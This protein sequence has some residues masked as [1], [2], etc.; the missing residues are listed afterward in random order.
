[1]SSSVA[2][3]VSSPGTRERTGFAAFAA[4]PVLAI[5]AAVGV[6]LAAVSG[7]Y[8]YFGDELYFLAAGRHL[9]WGY[10]DQPPLLPLLARALDTIAPGSVVVLR[11]PAVAVTVAGVVFGALIAREL[12]GARKAQVLTAAAYAC[13]GQFLGTG[14]YLATSTF[15]PFLWTVLLW[16]LTRWLRTRADGLLVWAG[17]VTAIAVNV[18]FLVLGF[19]LVLAVAVLVCGPRE[20]LKR[21]KLWAGAL[22]ALAGVLPTVLWQAANGWP[23]IRMGAAISAEVENVYGGRLL[24]LPGMALAAGILAG[25]VLLVAGLVKLL[26]TPE[27]RFL[28]W[29]TLGL[30]A[31]ILVVDGRSYYVAGMFAA[32]WAAAGVAIEQRRPAKWWRWVPTWP[33]FLL[34]FLLTVP[35]S[36]PLWPESWLAAHPTLPRPVFSYAEIG[37][38]ESVDSIAAAYRAAP[39]DTAIVTGFYW[40]AA[41]IDQFS[42]GL[43]EPYS[44]SRG[45]WTLGTP[46]ESAR[47]VLFVGADPRPLTGHF[48]DVRQAGVVT[49]A[50]RPDNAAAGTPIWLATGRTEP[51]S[52]LWPELRDWTT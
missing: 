38:P 25:M 20:L 31:L 6:L 40:Q 10:A 21:P 5:A 1:M 41:A 4:R 13:C 29:T 39:P 19:W 46:P 12:C 30:A 15:D 52:R 43:P 32:C 35:T 33:V 18:K 16:L 8:G 48:A 34:G 22:I 27:W 28:G 24:S 47:N 11:L 3:D 45:Y 26:R 7:R 9:A 2:R 14:H 49:T 51:W 36:V 50:G 42:G 23:Q 44:P 17:V 37:W